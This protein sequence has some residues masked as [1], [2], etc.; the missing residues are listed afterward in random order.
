MAVAT[1]LHNTPT[2]TKQASSR[3]IFRT[4]HR[5]S[6][7]ESLATH[8]SVQH[9]S[10]SSPAIHPSGSYELSPEAN[11]T[12]TKT[13]TSVTTSRARKLPS[14]R[15][16]HSTVKERSS[17]STR[18]PRQARSELGRS[19][20]SPS[21]NFTPLDSQTSYFAFKSPDTGSLRSPTVKKPPASHSANGVETTRGPPPAISTQRAFSFELHD[22]AIERGTLERS[23]LTVDTLDRLDTLNRIAQDSRQIRNTNPSQASGKQTLRQRPIDKR[24]DS[25]AEIPPGSATGEPMDQR[26]KR[27]S[28]EGSRLAAYRM[29]AQFKNTNQPLQEVTSNGLS[30]DDLFLNMAQIAGR[31]DGIEQ[32][33]KV[34]L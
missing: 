10:E 12:D 29:S 7:T 19:L 14:L 18:L 32:E 25:I 22:T 11:A 21:S 28:L 4:K 30:H 31:D 9:K 26:N 27:Y 17:P 1:R 16:S 6:K 13:I 20:H 33:R 5:R 23:K 15:S 2:E 3:D 24:S 8:Q 34:C